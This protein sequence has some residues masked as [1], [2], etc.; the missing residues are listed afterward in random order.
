MIGQE[1]MFCKGVWREEGMK[2]EQRIWKRTDEEG[3]GGVEDEG[4]RGWKKGEGIVN[5]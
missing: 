2:N 4:I 1:R 5:C 3:G